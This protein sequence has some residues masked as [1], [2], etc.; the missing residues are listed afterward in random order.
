[1][2]EER[3]IVEQNRKLR[4]QIQG[5]SRETDMKT[6]K[7]VRWRGKRL[8]IRLIIFCVPR[9]VRSESNESRCHLI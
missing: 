7:A 5:K 4:H 1:M 9:K 3:L 8:K 2:H 6:V